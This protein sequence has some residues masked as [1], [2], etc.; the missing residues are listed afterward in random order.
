MLS[1]A[2]ALAAS[3]HASPDPSGKVISN[4]IATYCKSAPSCVA[5]Q[6]RGLRH[7]LVISTLFDPPTATSVNCLARS[8]R[9]GPTNWVEAAACL[10][11]WSNGLSVVRGRLA[12]NFARTR[13]IREA[14]PAA[15]AS[16]LDTW[17]DQQ[18]AP[19]RPEAIR[20]VPKDRL[21]A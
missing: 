8:T 21:G 3:A 16:A 14:L 5:Q 9:G 2:L 4:R 19:I 11:T 10:G 6:N 7:F 1:L 17:I 18:N 13:P 15:A 20:L 12:A